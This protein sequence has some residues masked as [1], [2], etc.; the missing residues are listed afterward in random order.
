LKWHRLRSLHVTFPEMQH[1]VSTNA[2]QR[3]ALIPSPTATTDTETSTKPSDFLIRASQGH[4]LAIASEN[5]LTPLLPDDATAPQE[6][7]HG[8]DERSWDAIWKSGGLKRMGR[9]HVHFAAGMPDGEAAAK[10]DGGDGFVPTA[11]KRDSDDAPAV[12]DAARDV[13][14]LTLREDGDK[15]KEQVISGMRA[16]ANTLIWVDVKRSA[17]EGGL[18]WWKSAN[19]VVLTEGDE[20]GV[21]GLMWVTRVQRRGTGEVIYTSQVEGKEGKGKV[22]S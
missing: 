5:L 16:S 9:Q 3:F 15:G 13:S 10:G 20:N 6:V 11:G 19:G 18:K 14:A 1:I 2:K 22:E 8:T 7:V 4:S 17:A 12:A 21:V